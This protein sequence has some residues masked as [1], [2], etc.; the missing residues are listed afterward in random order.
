MKFSQI[1]LIVW[2]A[3]GF[4]L[5]AVLAAPIATFTGGLSTQ[6]TAFWGQSFTVVAAGP[7]DNILFNFFSDLPP[8]TPSAGGI[9]YLLSSQYLGAP[10][11]LSVATPGFLGQATPA[12]NVYTFNPAITLLPATQYFLYS[13]TPVPSTGA[14]ADLYAGGVGFVSFNAGNNFTPF[15]GDLHFLA[16]GTLAA[17]GVPEMDPNQTVAP[18]TIL[19]V[20]VALLVS[21]T[22]RG[23]P[24][25][26]LQTRN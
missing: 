16:Q 2:L 11:G 15:G 13:D 24:L 8:T 26:P 21:R 12:G 22:R 6:S 17:A 5:Q 3:L 10:N 4:S 9:A 7:V 1:L 19:L 18:L 20:L 23:L 14:N 25:N